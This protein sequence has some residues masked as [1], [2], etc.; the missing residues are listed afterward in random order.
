MLGEPTDPHATLGTEAVEQ[1]IALGGST[2]SSVVPL[3]EERSRSLY[4]LVGGAPDGKDVIAKRCPRSEADREQ[5]VYETLRPCCPGLSVE[6]YG[7][8][9]SDG[10]YAWLFLQDAAGRAFRL[11]DLQDRAIAGRWLGELHVAGADLPGAQLLRDRG[12]DHF[13]EYLDVIPHRAALASANPELSRTDRRDV[14]YTVEIC[15]RVRSQWA[16][17]RSFCATMPPTFV[18]GDFKDDNVRV[19]DGDRGPT[20]IGFDWNEAGW[21]VPALDVLTFAAHRVAPL[22]SEYLPVVAAR[23]PDLTEENILML[24]II[25]EIFRCGASMRWELQRLESPWTERAMAL[26]RYHNDWMGRGVRRLPWLR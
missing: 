20:L 22:L 6:L 2:P 17:V 8:A 10:Q 11:G 4:R 9:Q 13:V 25:G 18:F 16:R 3:Q 7:H 21:G 23:W 15:A 26:L 12:P 1:W 5:T 19:V 14:A 24:G